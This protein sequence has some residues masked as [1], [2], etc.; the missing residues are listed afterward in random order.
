MC[1]HSEHEAHSTQP[2]G[3]PSPA[4]VAAEGLVSWARSDLHKITN[5]QSDPQTGMEV[6]PLGSLKVRGGQGREEGSRRKCQ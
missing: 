5:R 4:S 3:T 1:T 2:L 6:L